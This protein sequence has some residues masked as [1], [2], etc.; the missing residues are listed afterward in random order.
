MDTFRMHD[1]DI[2]SREGKTSFRKDY[3][4]LCGF[5]KFMLDEN[6]DFIKIHLFMNSYFSDSQ[7]TKIFQRLPTCEAES[8]TPLWTCPSFRSDQQQ[9]C[10]TSKCYGFFTKSRSPNGKKKST[11]NHKNSKR[12]WIKAFL[13]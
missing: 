4:L 9:T 3:L 13:F 5:K 1:F 10:K 2:K 11:S 7:M 8:P 6:K 12:Q